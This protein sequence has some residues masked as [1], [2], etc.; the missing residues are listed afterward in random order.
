MA[1]S[2]DSD[3]IFVAAA[4]IERRKATGVCLN[5]QLHDAVA[6]ASG[7]QAVSASD[8]AYNL[9]SGFGAHSLTGRR[10]SN[11]NHRTVEIALSRS[12][13]WYRVRVSGKTFFLNDAVEAQRMREAA[14]AKH[15]QALATDARQRAKARALSE[16]FLSGSAVEVRV[17]Y[18]RPKG[19]YRSPIKPRI[20]AMTPATVLD[21]CAKLAAGGKAIRI[22]VVES[23]TF[24]TVTLA[25]WRQA[26]AQ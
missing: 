4:L 15:D 5:G 9:G 1:A 3:V 19:Q 6:G 26:A 12:E 17:F 22:D 23:K 11:C 13:G 25:T 10:W 2:F 20:V 7:F 21:E 16:R 24:S 18:R 8:V 14:S